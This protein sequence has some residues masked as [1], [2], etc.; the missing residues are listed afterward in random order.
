M[1]GV[2]ESEEEVVKIVAEIAYRIGNK[3]F[4]SE[5]A[6]MDHLAD[7]FGE[8]IDEIWKTI[9]LKGLSYVTTDSI[10]I[11]LVEKLW[12]NREKLVPLLQ[13]DPVIDDDLENLI[14]DFLDKR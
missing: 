2:L 11:E 6:A 3:S 9:D 5:K 12:E 7:N 4:R 13:V 1:L 10:L 14:E 8:C